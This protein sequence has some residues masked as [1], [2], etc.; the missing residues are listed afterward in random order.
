MVN[1]FDIRKSV[2]VLVRLFC[3]GVAC[4]LSGFKES[5]VNKSSNWWFSFVD[6]KNIY[7]G[8]GMSYLLKILSIVIL[9]STFTI[10][11]NYFS[12]TFSGRA[13]H[14]LVGIVIYGTYL[15]KGEK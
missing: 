2:G 14:V 1:H 10:R 11:T 15:S 4:E 5:T 6:Y 13:I 12:E 7:G 3:E 8:G 9:F